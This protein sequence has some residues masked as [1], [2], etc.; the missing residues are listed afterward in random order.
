MSKYNFDLDLNTENPVKMIIDRINDNSKILEFGPA[1]GRLT[2]YLKEKKN[3]V[4]DIVELDEESGTEASKYANESLVGLELGNIDNL[5]WFDKLKSYKYDYIIFADVLEHLRDPKTVLQRC[6][7]ILKENGSI[8]LSVPNI[9]H[10]SVL[11]NLFNDSFEYNKIGLLDNTH[12]HFFSYYSLKRLITECEFMPVYEKATFARVGEIEVPGKYEDIPPELAK[13]LINRPLG[14]LYSF[15]YEIKHREFALTNEI[16]SYK[17][18]NMDRVSYYNMR[19]YVRS[20]TQAISEDRQVY[21]F[22]DPRNNK[23]QL[24]LNEFDDIQEVIIYPL[25]KESIIKVQSIECLFENKNVD[26]KMELTGLD[27]GDNAFIMKKEDYIKIQ[28]PDKCIDKVILN[29][30]YLAYDSKLIDEVRKS[31]IHKIE[32]YDSSLQSLLE[33]VEEKDKY[34]KNIGGVVKEKD[35]YIEK[36]ANIMQ[37]KDDYNNKLSNT[38]KEKDVY[39]GEL[40]RIIQEKDEYNT[41]LSTVIQEKDGYSASLVALIQNKDEIVANVN[42]NIKVLKNSNEELVNE[43]RLKNE[44]LEK[45]VTSRAYKLFK[46]FI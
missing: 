9:A 4:I 26:F 15:V 38:I 45:I 29:I 21:S 10:N 11:I 5:K 2:K 43:I 35:E 17:A 23:F 13:V 42:E 41:K 32:T 3:C 31:M 16:V 19:C 37:E 12:I 33:T 46:K 8:L 27:L 40:T 25:N 30:F 6:K 44:E 34:I 39:I 18:I 24:H 20:Q 22:V 36:L 14:N 7:F 28:S 1:H